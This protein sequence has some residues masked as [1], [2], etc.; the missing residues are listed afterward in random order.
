[1]EEALY[2]IPISSTMNEALQRELA[3]IES[4][5]FQEFLNTLSG[6]GQSNTTVEA[7]ISKES[8]SLVFED[9]NGEEEEN[10]GIQAPASAKDPSVVDTIP[11]LHLGKIHHESLAHGRGSEHE[12]NILPQKF[13][14]EENSQ[15]LSSFMEVDDVMVVEDVPLTLKVAE[16]FRSEMTKASPGISRRDPGTAARVAPAIPLVGETQMTQYGE[17]QSIPVRDPGIAAKSP[18]PVRAVCLTS[19]LQFEG[20]PKSKR[21]GRFPC[22]ECH[23]IFRQSGNLRKHV[24]EIHR[25]RKPFACSE[26]SSKFSRK[27]AR[28]THLR[29]VHHKLR[30]F[31]CS[32]CFK[33]Y[34]NRSDLNKHVRTV[35]RKEKPYACEICNKGFGERG[36]LKRH[37]SVHSN[38][39]G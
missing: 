15:Y 30:P 20:K 28:D 3:D 37:M 32:D 21:V 27:H 26:C 18:T 19:A 10:K 7:S 34:K 12:I 8:A 35:E 33:R 39:R 13:Q 22:S 23:L 17:N 29:A 38:K 6:K 1:M 5:C 14:K 9:Q 4:Q 36:K 2:D 16:F 31:Q 24:D 11:S 25:K